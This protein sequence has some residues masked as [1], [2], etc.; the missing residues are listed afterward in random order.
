M[1]SQELGRLSQCIEWDY[2]S[3]RNVLP[4]SGLLER[5]TE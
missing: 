2:F 5:L 4:R 1:S 3:A